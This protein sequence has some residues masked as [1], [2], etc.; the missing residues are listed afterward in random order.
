MFETIKTVALLGLLTGL[1]LGVGYYLGGSGG[2]SMA[3]IFSLAMNFF[4]Y[5]YSDKI[6]LKMY[7]AKEISKS[8]NPKIHEMVEEISEDVGIPKPKIYLVDQKAP[9]AFATGRNPKS[10]AL[11]VTSGL[12]DI[13]DEGEL[14]GVLAHEIAHIRNRDTLIS[15]LAATFAGALAFIAQTAY[16]GALFGGRDRGRNPAGLMLM[17]IF[18]PLAATI[19]R[20]AISRSREFAADRTGAL[21]IGDIDGLASALTKISSASKQIHLKGNA[22]TS[23]MFIINPF[24]GDFF[25]NLL[26]THPSTEARV[27][28]LRSLKI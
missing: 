12:M 18:V 13:L 20:L 9:N 8:Q 28:N 2:A 19:V 7:N 24:S 26:S 4:A 1:F 22:A 21:A 16:Y 5:W 3:L 10:G 27:K 14:K 11:A 23:H 15:T 25:V 6:V 17:V